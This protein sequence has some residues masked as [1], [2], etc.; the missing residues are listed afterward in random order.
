MYQSK[1]GGAFSGLDSVSVHDAKLELLSQPNATAKDHVEYSQYGQFA[2]P[3]SKLT[4][5]SIYKLSL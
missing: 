5:I 3:F 4:Q 1:T 2:N